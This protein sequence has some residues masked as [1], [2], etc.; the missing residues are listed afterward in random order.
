MPIGNKKLVTSAS[1]MEAPV[2]TELMSD[3][4]NPKYLKRNNIPASAI[5]PNTSSRF[6]TCALWL[7]WIARAKVQQMVVDSNKINP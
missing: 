1:K 2:L 3:V 5:I 6:R 7:R 4:K